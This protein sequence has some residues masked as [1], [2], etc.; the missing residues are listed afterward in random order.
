[1]TEEV[2][3]P[4]PPRFVL[5]ALLA[6]FA[7]SAIVTALL[8]RGWLAADRPEPPPEISAL[9][10]FELTNRDGRS[11][12]LADLDGEIWVADFIFTRCGGVCPRMTERMIRL[13]TSVGGTRLRRVSISV[14]PTFDTPDV[15]AAYAEAFRITDTDWLFLT[16]ERDAIYELTVG[17]FKL[18]VDD[19]PPPQSTHPDEPILHSNRFVLVD[20]RGTIRGYYD[21]F[22]PEELQRLLRDANQLSSP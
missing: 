13:E 4:K 18:A 9:P 22:R 5:P 1:V 7:L 16:G 3:R 20:R 11:V 2:S 21:P 17:G 10:D 6:L 12:R 8:A 14:D 15:L 19:E